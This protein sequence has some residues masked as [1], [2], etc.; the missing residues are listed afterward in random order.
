M[1]NIF[2]SCYLLS[3]YVLTNFIDLFSEITVK[4]VFKKSTAYCK[5]PRGCFPDL[6]QSLITIDASCYADRRIHSSYKLFIQPGCISCISVSQ[7]I[8]SIDTFRKIFSGLKDH[9]FAGSLQNG[10]AI[11]D[12]SY[13]WHIFDSIFPAKFIHS[14]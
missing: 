4:L 1:D 8:N 9:L 12:F 5:C 3:F 6:I 2:L 11:M 13:K 7:K 10:W 14:I